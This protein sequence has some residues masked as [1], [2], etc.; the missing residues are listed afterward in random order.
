MPILH[1]VNKSPFQ[2][3]SMNSCLAICSTQDRVIFIEDGVLGAIHDTP[4]TTTIEK[5]S[6][7]GTKFYALSQDTNARGVTEKLLTCVTLASYE[8]FVRLSVEAK[9]I[10]SWY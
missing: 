10:Q 6:V 5:L 7:S 3:L 4:L 9:Q 2:D 8:D 1:T